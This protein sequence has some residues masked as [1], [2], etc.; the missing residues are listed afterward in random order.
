MSSAFETARLSLRLVRQSDRADLIALEQ[1]PE[2]M[3]FLNG[4]K[5]TPE[6][7]GRADFL[8]PRGG[9][10]D[11]WV[12]FEKS[13]GGFIGWF[14]LHATEPGAAELGFRLHREV[15]G[16]GLATEGCQALMAKGFGEFGLERIIASTMAVN[17][18]SR[19]LLER[20]GLRH[21]RTVLGNWTE[22]IPGNEHGDVDYE[23]TRQEWQKRSPA[24][25]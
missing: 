13:N 25:I 9:E 5:P 20:L 19:R 12:A 7:G 1:D 15:W 3:R 14:I 24:A 21:S 6:E 2:V 16:R 11:V 22:P 10:P 17:L 4:G 18:R 8:M 23:I